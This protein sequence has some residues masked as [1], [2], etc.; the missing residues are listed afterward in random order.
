NKCVSAAQNNGDSS[1][2]GES[3]MKNET[4]ILGQPTASLEACLKWAFLSVSEPPTEVL[5]PQGFLNDASN[6]P[7]KLQKPVS[8]AD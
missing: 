7:P 2:K 1:T 3:P 4:S 5:S 8:F 6:T